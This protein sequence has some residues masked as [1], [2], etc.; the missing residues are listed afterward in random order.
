MITD[1]AIASDATVLWKCLRCDPNH[2]GVQGLFRR[3]VSIEGSSR[4][5]RSH[6]RRSSRVART[7]QATG[8]VRGE[9][10]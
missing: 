2:V 10:R 6:S 1:L 9:I 3:D 4:P 8:A 5:S 7:A